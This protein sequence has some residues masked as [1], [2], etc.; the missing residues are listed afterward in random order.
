[1]FNS[2]DDASLVSGDEFKDGMPDG[3]EK[4]LLCFSR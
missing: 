2:D 4:K 1:M 3:P